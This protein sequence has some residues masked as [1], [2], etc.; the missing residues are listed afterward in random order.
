MGGCNCEM[1]L[2]IVPTNDGRHLLV[3]KCIHCRS[4][5]RL[6]PGWSKR[7]LKQESKETR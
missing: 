1:K 6:F 4:Y 7:K 2:T 3:E 5:Q